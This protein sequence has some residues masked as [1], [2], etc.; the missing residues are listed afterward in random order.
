MRASGAQLLTR[1]GCEDGLKAT[2]KLPDTFGL[3]YSFI[4]AATDPGSESACRVGG[5]QRADRPT[6]RQTSVQI[7]QLA[8]QCVDSAISDKQ[9]ADRPERRQTAR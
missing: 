8:D 5:D 6:R 4:C 2:G 3:H 9:R 1:S 7:D